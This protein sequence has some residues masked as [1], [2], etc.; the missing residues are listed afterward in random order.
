M[1]DPLSDNEVAA[2]RRGHGPSKTHVVDGSACTEYCET[3]RWLATLD[4]CEGRV[5]QALDATAPRD[6]G[7][8]A[9]R[10]LS[11][12]SEVKEPS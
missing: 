1:I 7:L 6:A 4:E 9:L 5:D 12:L 11:D 8:E 2:I 3:L 10:A